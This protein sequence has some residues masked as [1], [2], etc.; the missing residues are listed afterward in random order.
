MKAMIGD[1]P[2]LQSFGDVSIGNTISTFLHH[3]YGHTKKN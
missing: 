1:E 2:K 3:L